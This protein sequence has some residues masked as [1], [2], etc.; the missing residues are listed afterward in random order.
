[1]V[2]P[3][4]EQAF[5]CPSLQGPFSLKSS[6]SHAFLPKPS[7]WRSRPSRF[8]SLQTGVQM[9][10]FPVAGVSLCPG[11]VLGWCP[12]GCYPLPSHCNQAGVERRPACHYTL[13][14]GCRQY[15]SS[16]LRINGSPRGRG[17]AE[18]HEC[19]NGSRWTT[20]W[21]WR[22]PELESVQF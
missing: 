10:L 2:L 21:G 20:G 8:T 3:I 15:S 16:N 6:H 5:K 13:M 12:E 7:G 14:S 17:Y 18:F 1:M 4:G 9:T 19:G 22:K 11:L